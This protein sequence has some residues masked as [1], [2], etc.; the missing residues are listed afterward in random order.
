MERCVE[1]YGARSI[2]SGIELGYSDDAVLW[3]LALGFKFSR[4]SERW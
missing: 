1:S 2:L 3:L 4:R